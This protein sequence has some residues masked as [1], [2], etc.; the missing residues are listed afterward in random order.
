VAAVLGAA[1]SLGLDELIGP[2]PSRRRDLAVAMVAAQ[3]ISPA[4]KPGIA[5][6]L[7]G[8]PRPKQPPTGPATTTQRTAS[9]PCSKTSPPSRS[10]ASNQPT[11]L[12]PRFTLI[13]TPTPVQRRAFELLGVSQRLSAA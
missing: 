4:S 8:E 11:P 3:V 5:R 10:T 12:W 2:A 13:T 6:G 1:R 9:R 7:R